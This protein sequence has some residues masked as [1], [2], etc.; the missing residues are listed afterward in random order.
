MIELDK[1]RELLFPQADALDPV[2]V[3]VEEAYGRVLREEIRADRDFPPTDRSAMDG[4]A[5]VAAD[6]SSGER[7]LEV[8]GES[9]A[10]GPS[11][12]VRLEPGQAVRIMTGGVV[13]PGADAVVMVE[14]SRATDSRDRVT[15]ADRPAP[16][17]HIRPRGQDIGAGEIVLD[18]G[19]V[20]RPQDLGL[21]ASIGCA[22]VSVFRPLR[23]AVLSTGDELFEPGTG[24]LP[25]GAMILICLA[26]PSQASRSPSV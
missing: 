11:E 25:E 17:Q 2:E 14:N 21:L 5:V 19:R 6:M 23:V 20:L 10:G 22:G 9:R 7:I 24:N 16:G 1:A 4:F 13:P 3:E 26:S 8:V 15:I 12:G 18:C